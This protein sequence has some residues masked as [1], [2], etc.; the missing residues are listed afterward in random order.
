L[1]RREGKREGGRGRRQRV[2][3]NQEVQGDEQGVLMVVEEE[4]AGAGSEAPLSNAHGTVEGK[5]GGGGGRRGRRERGGR[6]LFLRLFSL[7]LACG[8]DGD[9]GRRGRGGRWRR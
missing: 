6:I 4:E 1:R 8:S 2:G 5:E 3:R 7:S 9:G